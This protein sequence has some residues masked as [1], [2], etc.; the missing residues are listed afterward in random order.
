MLSSLMSYT[1]PSDEKKYKLQEE[2][3]QLFLWGQVTS[4]FQ[5]SP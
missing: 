5:E 3:L 1:Y 4:L 2:L